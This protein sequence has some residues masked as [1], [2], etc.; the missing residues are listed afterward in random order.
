[1][2]APVLPQGLEL[3]LEGKVGSRTYIEMTLQLMAQ[4][5]ISSSWEGAT[6]KIEPQAYQTTQFTVE[7]DW[8]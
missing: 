2:I 4:F 3:E 6:I 1:M 7:S 5:G 8:S